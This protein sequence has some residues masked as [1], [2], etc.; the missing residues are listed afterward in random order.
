[1]PHT[2]RVRVTYQLPDRKTPSLRSK[3][4]GLELDDA[5]WERLDEVRRGI[6]VP[7]RYSGRQ[8]PFELVEDQK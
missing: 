1:M 2:P 6:K 3:P 5:H 7:G 4:L 8:R